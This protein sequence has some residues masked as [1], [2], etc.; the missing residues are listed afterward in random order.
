MPEIKDKQLSNTILAIL[1]IFAALGLMAA[2]DALIRWTAIIAAVYAAATM[3][4]VVAWLTLAIVRIYYSLIE[5]HNKYTISKSQNKARDITIANEIKLT[6]TRM[7]TEGRQ[8]LAAARKA[9]REAQLFVIT[10]KRDEQVFISDDDITKKFTAAQLQLSGQV[11][12]ALKEAT[13]QQ[14]AAWS[15]FHAPQSQN[16]PTMLTQEAITPAVPP[17]PI[18]PS[19]VNRQRI[20]IIGA[21]DA[22][23]TTLLR[24]LI[25]AREGKCLIIDPHGAPAKWGKT[26][27]IG[28]GL[29]YSAIKAA[30]PQLLTEMKKRHAEIGRGEVLESQHSQL[31]IIIDEFRG[32]VKHCKDAGQQISD[33][34]TDGRKTQMNLIVT[35]H[36]RYVKALGIE[37]E[38]DLRKGFTICSL[39]GGNGEPHYAT[40]EFNADGNEIEHALPG[41]HPD[42][43]AA[44]LKAKTAPKILTDLESILTD[45]PEPKPASDYDPKRAEKIREMYNKGMKKT[46]IARAFDY[47]ANTGA[48]FYE[49][50]AA[51]EIATTTTKT[52]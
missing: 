15:T 44:K 27:Q 47:K 7:L 21:S 22:G 34:L 10:A 39:R 43:E 52:A 19:L 24:W 1:A 14:M 12:G 51:L 38:G 49:I 2:W 25:E 6:E 26:K 5:R 30:L 41:P 42:I 35:S 4:A 29:D 9:E 31:T 32:I 23:K 48:I 18:I 50:K 20:L 17:Q 3:I 33:L 40:L 36:S 11:N 46:E 8:L 45:V 16:T 28:R 37:G 13:P